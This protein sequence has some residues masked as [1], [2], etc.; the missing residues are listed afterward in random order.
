MT[1]A[2]TF[3]WRKRPYGRTVSYE[4]FDRPQGQSRWTVGSCSRDGRN[5]RACIHG[6][7]GRSF[8]TVWATG[9][10]AASAMKALQR[11][12]DRQSIGLF[13]VDDVAFI[14]EGAS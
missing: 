5:W 6:G 10:T 1:D 7:A 9:G 4:M 2:L 12:I 8:P 11:E 14:T 3:Y 13:N